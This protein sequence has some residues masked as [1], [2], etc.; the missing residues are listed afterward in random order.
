M[1]QSSGN[2]LEAS[3]L[4]MDAQALPGA[5]ACAASYA[6]VPEHPHH[7]SSGSGQRDH[8]AVYYYVTCVLKVVAVGRLQQSTV[9]KAKHH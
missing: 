6:L 4:G 8:H 7:S 5:K 1:L 3:R 9:A 2:E